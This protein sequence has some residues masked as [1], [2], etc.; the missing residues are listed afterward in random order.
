MNKTNQSS[1]SLENVISLK[2]EN[3]SHDK[4]YSAGEFQSQ[5]EKLQESIV[6]ILFKNAEYIRS[7]CMCKKKFLKT[8]HKLSKNC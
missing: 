2:F 7:R 3:L 4:S 5:W 8:C 1:V 6:S